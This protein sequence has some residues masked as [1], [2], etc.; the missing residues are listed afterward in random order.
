MLTLPSMSNLI[1]ST[2]VFIFA[3]WYFH[4]YFET[5]GIPKGLTRTL[6]V[7]VLAYFVSWGAGELVDW[8]QGPQAESQTSLE[9]NQLF[10]SAGQ[11]QP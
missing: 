7:F 10:K 11:G 4:R 8:V 9:L 6:L 2:L 1:V 5:Q 3:A